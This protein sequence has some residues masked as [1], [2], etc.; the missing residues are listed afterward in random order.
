MKTLVV[1]PSKN[2][3]YSNY[4]ELI[5][6]SFD[7]EVVP[8][9]TNK[10]FDVLKYCYTKKIEKVIFLHGDKDFLKSFILRLFF[11]KIKISLIIYYTLDISSNNILKNIKSI[12]LRIIS[13]FGINLFFL[14]YDPTN[15]NFVRKAFV[16]KIY[17]PVLLKTPKKLV[18]ESKKNSIKYLVAGF[19]DKRKNIRLL[20]DLLEDLCKSD[21]KTREITL[22]GSQSKNITD[23]IS[24][25]KVSK[26]LL[27]N[28][29]NYRFSDEE[30]ENELT[31]NDIVWAYYDKHHG[32]SSS[33]I[34]NSVFYNRKVVYKNSGIPKIFSTELKIKNDI[35]YNIKNYLIFLENNDQYTSESRLMFLS[36]R[37]KS[38]FINKLK[39]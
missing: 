2:G 21:G 9:L 38:N 3:H 35:I 39:N 33:V 1:Y 11:F 15:I 6:N 26:N 27:I 5:Q 29:K 28:K 17:D 36:K 10:T 23:L 7:D 24:N 22:L 4:L 8:L 31:E 13:F 18:K 32:G 19:L 14:E 16:H 20:V 12:F 25:L 30:F 34:I 37:T